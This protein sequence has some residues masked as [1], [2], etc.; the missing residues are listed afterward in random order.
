MSRTRILIIA[1]FL[2]SSPK[3]ERSIWT[4]SFKELQFSCTDADEED[5][6][7]IFSC[8]RKHFYIFY[9]FFLLATTSVKNLF[10]EFFMW[11]VLDE[12]Y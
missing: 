2:V 3:E 9:L 7:N 8:K 12:Q 10:F 5:Q 4:A 6:C 1:I 11:L